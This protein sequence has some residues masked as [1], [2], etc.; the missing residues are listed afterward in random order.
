MKTYDLRDAGEGCINNPAIALLDVLSRREKEVRI[1]AKKS[2]LP[3]EI[4]R[5]VAKVSG[6][7]VESVE[8][9]EGEITVVLRLV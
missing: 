7:S 1:I 3:P 9:K 6:Y 4:V 2:D 8:E 5:E